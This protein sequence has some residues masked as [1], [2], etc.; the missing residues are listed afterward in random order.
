[1]TRP[2]RPPGRDAQDG[3]HP[4]GAGRPITTPPPSRREVTSRLQVGTVTER[5]RAAWLRL[6]DERDLQ[7]RLRLD[8]WRD[9]YQAG[10]QAGYDAGYLDGIAAR[11]HAQH[12]LVDVIGA[13]LA[14]WDGL[15]RDFG[16][17]R[18]GEYQGGPVEFY[19][20]GRGS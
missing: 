4:P 10:H 12:L 2:D 20:R 17:P 18:P 15:R 13:H 5:Q 14:R 8:A 7:L 9:G 16:K 11:K 19:G 1:M 6:S 3:P